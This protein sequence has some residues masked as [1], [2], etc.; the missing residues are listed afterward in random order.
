MENLDVWV[1]SMRNAFLFYR[2]IPYLK[3][4]DDEFDWVSYNCNYHK[5]Y[6]EKLK[7]VIKEII[8]YLPNEKW[9]NENWSNLF[10]ARKSITGRYCKERFDFYILMRVFGYKKIFLKRD[11]TQNLFSI[12]FFRIF[13][14]ESCD[15]KYLGNDLNV[16]TL[17]NLITNIQFR[18]ISTVNSIDLVNRYRQYFPIFDGLNF[19][20]IEGDVIFDCGA[21]IGDTAVLFNSFVGE[22][23]VVHC[24]DP[25]PYHHRYLNEQSKLNDFSNLKCCMKAVSNENLDKDVDVLFSRI[26][27]GGLKVSSFSITTIDE[28][29][30]VNS[31]NR[32]D[33]IKMD[34]EGFELQAI[35][36]AEASIKKFRPKLAICAYHKREDLWEIPSKVLSFD[37]SYK[38]Y[39]DLHTPTTDEAVFYFY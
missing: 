10:N 25:V 7:N 37:S 1:R 6:F 23:G 27:P 4:N 29:C 21:C 19:T 26:E 15:T 2:R 28:Y 38:V 13:E 39:F 3:R 18:V 31:I 16:F 32:L 36:G 30:L 35:E 33:Y 22:T 20:P 14:S 8:G 11:Y 34:I 12:D 24:F 17:T 5:G 9:V